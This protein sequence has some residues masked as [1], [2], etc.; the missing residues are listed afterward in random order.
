MIEHGHESVQALIWTFV[1]MWA[2]YL[3]LRFVALPTAIDAFRQDVFELRRRL[4]RW[5]A[6]GNIAPNDLAYIHTRETMNALLRYAERVSFF[7]SMLATMFL[8]DQV[9]EYKLWT[10]ALFARIPEKR[11]KELMVFRRDLD[12]VVGKHLILTSPVLLA[13]AA[14]VFVVALGVAVVRVIRKRLV[15][16]M[17]TATAP[18]RRVARRLAGH[19]SPIPH[20]AEVARRRAREH[21]RNVARKMPQTVE[22]EAFVTE[23]RRTVAA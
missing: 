18:G 4:F 8:R 9:A 16:A 12:Y 13:T 5:M 21:V 20:P 19:E 14:C 11:R 1:G 15:R 23:G 6:D 7:R 17:A 2:L 3:A 22:A 10:D